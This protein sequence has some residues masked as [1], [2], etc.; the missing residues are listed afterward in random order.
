M[1]LPP[2]FIS[3]HRFFSNDLQNVKYIAHNSHTFNYS[4]LGEGFDLVFIDGDHSRNGVTIDTRH[5]FTILRDQQSV[6]VWHDYGHSP[7]TVR[8]DVLAGILDGAPPSAN[9]SLY[10]VSNTMCAI[11]INGDFPKRY[12]TGFQVPDK[13]F[14]LKVAAQRWDASKGSD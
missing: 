10:H 13:V 6:I 8:W 11:Y 3:T 2:E 1:G 9:G 5:I 12:A 14:T 7:E 4:M